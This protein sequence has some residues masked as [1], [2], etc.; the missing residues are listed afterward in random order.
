MSIVNL[1]AYKFISLD[2]LDAW[3]P[4]VRQRCDELGLRG[5]ILLAPEGINLFIAGA[6][7][8]SDAF[9]DYLRGDPLF[10]GKFTDLQ[11][12][13]SLSRHGSTAATTTRDDRS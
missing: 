10:G 2:T 9:I 3:R 1:A 6:R 4:L 5:T 7:Q 8:A 11:F 13:V 12:K